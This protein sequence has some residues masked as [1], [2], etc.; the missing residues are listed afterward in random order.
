MKFTTAALSVCLALSTVCQLTAADR[1]APSAYIVV[2]EGIVGGFAP[3]HVRQR[4]IVVQQNGKF[5]LFVM[6]QPARNSRPEYRHGVLTAAGFQ[7][8]TAGL[9]KSVGNLPV[10]VPAGCQDIYKIDTSLTLHSGGEFW[11]N[12]GPGG[13]AHGV[14]KVQPTAAQQKQFREAVATVKKLAA[15]KANRDSTADAFNKVAATVQRHA[16]QPANRKRR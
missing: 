13:C 2:T 15:A 11:R 12:G 10:E 4:T 6:K 14:S 8:L 5:E 3:A 7:T 16:A 1:A 9:K